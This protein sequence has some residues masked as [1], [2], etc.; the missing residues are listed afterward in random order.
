MASVQQSDSSNK[1][2][3]A[4]TWWTNYSYFA[5][6]PPIHFVEPELDS[7]GLY[8]IGVFRHYQALKARDPARAAQFL[9]AVWPVAQKAANFV[10]DSAN[11]PGNFGFGAKDASILEEAQE[12][13][14]FTQTTYVSG[15]RAATLLAQERKDATSAQ[16]WS[17]AG[18]TIAFAIFRDTLIAPCPGVWHAVK[19]HFIR[20]VW[21]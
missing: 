18:S 9:D 11:A 10:R 19:S 20:G 5:K 3:P 4:G 17:Q 1:D 13:V 15:L 16:A 8:L 6:T 12:F 21:S 14:T 7:V 2:V